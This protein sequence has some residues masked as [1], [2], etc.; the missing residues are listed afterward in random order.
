MCI[1]ESA[2]GPGWAYT[3]GVHDTCGQPELITVGLRSE[4]AQGMLNE[5]VDRLRQGIDLS[6]GR[7]RDLL[8]NVECE[9]RPVDPKWVEHLMG[10]ANWYNESSGY[11]VLQA[12]YPDLENRFPEEPGFDSAFAQPLMQPG[13]PTSVLERDFWASADPGSS[14]FSWKFEDGPH[15]GVFVSEAVFNGSEPVT[16]VSHDIE[17]GAWQF[18]GNSMSGSR[19]AKFSCFHHIVDTD[20]SLEELADLPLGWHAVRVAPGEPWSRGESPPEEE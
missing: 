7:H 16:Y 9:F 3:I 2:A 19:Q 1:S 15:T 18:H 6:R 13:A 20:R 5:A 10:W 8:G 12:V 17:D 14:L 4:T 11:P